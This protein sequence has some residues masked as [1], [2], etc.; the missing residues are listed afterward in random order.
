MIENAAAPR[1]DGAGGCLP[2]G[3]VPQVPPDAAEIVFAGL[4]RR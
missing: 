2:G 1:L 3:L 4:A